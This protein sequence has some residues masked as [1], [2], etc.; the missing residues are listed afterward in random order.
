VCGKGC[1]NIFMVFWEWNIQVKKEAALRVETFL[2]IY[3]TAWHEIPEEPKF[4]W[5]GTCLAAEME[6][7]TP[8]Q[9]H[10][11]GDGMSLEA[12]TLFYDVI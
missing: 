10:S 2:L 12:V 4:A 8:T 3:K 7:A 6:Y 5:R 1:A 11:E 9:W